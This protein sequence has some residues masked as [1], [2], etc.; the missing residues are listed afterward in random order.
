MIRSIPLEK[1]PRYKYTGD[2][3]NRNMF[4]ITKEKDENG[5]IIFLNSVSDTYA[6]MSVAPPDEGEE[7][8][9]AISM[10]K[11]IGDTELGNKEEPDDPKV[12]LA[13]IMDLD[14]R[15]EGRQYKIAQFNEV[16]KKLN[17]EVATQKKS[18]K[19]GT[20][21]LYLCPTGGF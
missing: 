11:N 14:S 5:K 7:T 12:K 13:H 10:P 6:D 1:H 9:K 15:Q 19:K 21:D 4:D 3:D 2:V 17:I 18:G 20:F 16:T 8:L